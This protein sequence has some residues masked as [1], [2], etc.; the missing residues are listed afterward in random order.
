[1]TDMNRL[2]LFLAWLF[3]ASAATALTWGVLSSADREVAEGPL[4][5]GLAVGDTRPPDP[6]DGSLPS[7]SA[8]SV[9]TPTSSVT[10]TIPTDSSHPPVTGGGTDTSSAPPV[11]TAPQGTTTT[12]TTVSQSS[13]STTTT[14]ASPGEAWT[15]LTVPSGGGVVVV[16]HRPGEVRL[17]SAAPTAGFAMEIEKQGPDEVRVEFRSST[18]RFDIRIR[19]E[20]GVLDTQVGGEEEDD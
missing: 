11:E 3:V 19:W 10:S 8:A 13:P 9:K 6:T 4:S 18:A 14:V 20:N 17:E 12:S 16:S 7:S 15:K 2:G 1:M 5:Q